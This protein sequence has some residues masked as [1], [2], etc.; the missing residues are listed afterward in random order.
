MESRS[1]CP[2]GVMRRLQQGGEARSA[3][4][5]GRR[6]APPPVR[7]ITTP[8][9]PQGKANAPL[10]LRDLLENLQHLELLQ[11]VAR[12]GPRTQGR[13]LRPRSPAL[14]SAVNLLERT[15]T[16]AA[17]DVHPAGHGSCAGGAARRR[18]VR[19]NQQRDAARAQCCLSRR[20]LPHSVST[21]AARPGQSSANLR[22][23]S[24]SRHRTEP[25]PCTRR[26]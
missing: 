7:R 21:H 22:E 26:S 11:D 25:S 1:R 9:R 17:A 18:S 3:R 6:V 2:C 10:A 24:T 15:H 13:L 4:A 16:C 19:C 23:C 20:C 5:A 12:D 8:A 14:A